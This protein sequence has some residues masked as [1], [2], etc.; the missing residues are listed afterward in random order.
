[1]KVWQ[2]WIEWEDEIARRGGGVDKWGG[3][4]VSHKIYDLPSPLLA[5]RG[6][7]GY[8]L[9]FQGFV[10]HVLSFLEISRELIEFA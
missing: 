1:M 7:F 2:E 4:G 5:R 10:Q 9:D 3:G 6:I 8:L